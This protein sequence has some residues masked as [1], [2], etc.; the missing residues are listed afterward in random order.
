MKTS[1]AKYINQSFF[2][3]ILYKN[4]LTYM[5]FLLVRLLWRALTDTVIATCIAAPHPFAA[6]V[7]T[8][9]ITKTMHSQ[10]ETSH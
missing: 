8:R 2:I 7:R 4:I 10:L 1:L 5:Y 3:F 9:S 6:P